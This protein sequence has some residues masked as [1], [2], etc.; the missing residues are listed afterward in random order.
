MVKNLEKMCNKKGCKAK[1][2]PRKVFLAYISMP[3]FGSTNNTN[4]M[5]VFT[6][7]IFIEDFEFQH[8]HYCFFTRDL[9][10]EQ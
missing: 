9:S 6:V 8:L 7:N 10:Q 1:M 3:K 4:F 2:A 5:T